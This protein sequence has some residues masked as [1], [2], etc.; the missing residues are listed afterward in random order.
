MS[1]SIIRS[2]NNGGNYPW[3]KTDAGRSESS[4]PR[5]KNDCT[6][7]ALSIARQISYDD[8][9]DILLK[10]GRKSGCRF[11]LSDWINKQSWVKKISFPAVKG[12]RRMNPATFVV[13]YPKGVFICKV[14]KHVFTIKDGVVFDDFEIAPD[15]CIYT[16]WQ[17]TNNVN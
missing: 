9:Y 14:A 16:A 10:A 4:L 17:I 6:V 7:R 15:R 11:K 1:N 8:A 3:A 13:Q 5:Q 2:I 12:Q